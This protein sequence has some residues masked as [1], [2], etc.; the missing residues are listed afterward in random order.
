[1]DGDVTE[2][3]L[4]ND[5]RTSDL[6]ADDSDDEEGVYRSDDPEED[7][8]AVDSSFRTKKSN[9]KGNILTLDHFWNNTADRSNDKP[10]VRKNILWDFTV[11]VNLREEREGKYA[12]TALKLQE[13]AVASIKKAKEAILADIDETSNEENFRNDVIAV[14]E[15]Q[16]NELVRRFRVNSMEGKPL[17]EP[18][19]SSLKDGE[20]KIAIESYVTSHEGF[21]KLKYKL[22]A[23]RSSKNQLVSSSLSRLLDSV[24]GLRNKVVSQIYEP[25]SKEFKRMT[26]TRFLRNLDKISANGDFAGE[27]RYNLLK[28]YVLNKDRFDEFIQNTV[29]FG[30]PNEDLGKFE[31]FVNPFTPDF[32][33]VM[34]TSTSKPETGETNKEM[35]V[36]GVEGGSRARDY[37]KE[38][39]DATP[40]DDLLIPPTQP[41]SQETAQDYPQT[42]TP[43]DE[44]LQPTASAAVNAKSHSDGDI[45]NDDATQ[46]RL[47][48]EARKKAAEILRKKRLSRTAGKDNT[49]QD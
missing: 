18:S 28:T 12:A 15:Q 33:D 21:K 23:F 24:N 29:N 27:Y 20:R 35:D 5:F 43:W 47:L 42:T 44:T 39:M 6:F 10:P 14:F 40:P 1:M 4:N 3:D 2:D 48:E 38:F 22:A 8:S 49:G 17:F 32:D 25:N 45:D 11:Y 26:T 34:A 9:K 46:I 13:E 7:G 31:D 19:S 16:V 41:E 30:D 37:M 36:D